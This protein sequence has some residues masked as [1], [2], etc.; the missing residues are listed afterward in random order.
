MLIMLLYGWKHTYGKANTKAFLIHSNEIGLEVNVE[1][2][3]YM[4]ISQG[5]QVGRNHNLM[6]GNKSFKKVEQFRY[7]GTT[8][9]VQTSIHEEIKCGP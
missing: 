5:Q 9:T 6:T 8:L 3:K 1:I 2:T 4:F 7:S